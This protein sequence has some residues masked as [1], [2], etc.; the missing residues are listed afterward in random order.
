[1]STD[2]TAVRLTLFA[3]LATFLVV[4]SLL[5]NPISLSQSALA[6]PSQSNHD[7]NSQNSGTLDAL[8][9]M[10]IKSFSE[11]WA[12]YSPYHPATPFEPSAR[13]GCVVSQVNIV[14]CGYVITHFLQIFTLYY[15]FNAMEP[16]SPPLEPRT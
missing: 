9:E 10:A 8:A 14:S 5:I 15:S 13:K 2:I 1:M 12:Y 11:S 6:R 4:A 16:V 7:D 3:L